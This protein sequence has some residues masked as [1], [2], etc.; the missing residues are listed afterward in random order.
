MT[1]NLMRTFASCFALLLVV[2]MATLLGCNKD[3][4]NPA[5]PPASG[6]GCNFA[7]DVVAVNGTQHPVIRA[8]VHTAPSYG[9]EF[10]TDTSAAPT[11]VAVIFA[12]SAAPDTGTYAIE[13]DP[14]S[15]V[16]GKVYV[17]YYDAAN[18]WHGTS[19]SLHVAAGSGGKVFTFCSLELTATPSDKKTVSLRGTGS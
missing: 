12:G 1:M 15:L 3:E 10:F 6:G 19:G 11:A 2:L 13:A 14:G 18:A 4:S 17:E 5:Q 16:A 8:L 7:T 9:A